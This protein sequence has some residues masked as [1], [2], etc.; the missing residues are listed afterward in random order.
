MDRGRYGGAAVPIVQADLVLAI[1]AVGDSRCRDTDRLMLVGTAAV[2]VDAVAACGFVD[3]HDSR[4]AGD[5]RDHHG[6]LLEVRDEHDGSCDADRETPE[7]KSD[8]EG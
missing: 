8:A 5:I 7:C 6:A 1:V 2:A 4:C 3:D